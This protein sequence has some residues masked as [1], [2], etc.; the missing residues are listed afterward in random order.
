MIFPWPCVFQH[1][2]GLEFPV[3]ITIEVGIGTGNC[4]WLVAWLGRDVRWPSMFR[5]RE[6]HFCSLVCLLSEQ[7]TAL[8]H[9]NGNPRKPDFDD[10]P[11]RSWFCGL[12]V[13]SFDLHTSRG[14][15]K[16]WGRLYHVGG[17]LLRMRTIFYFEL[18]VWGS[19]QEAKYTVI[20]EALP[21]CGMYND[22]WN[23]PP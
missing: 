13:Q 16:I 23:K 21:R 2:K 19:I 9:R 22:W 20:Y 7:W 5:N 4:S 14:S 18:A 1:M 8:L 6:I 10:F 3:G 17:L 12:S 11:S 15:S